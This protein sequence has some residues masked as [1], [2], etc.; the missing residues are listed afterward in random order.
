MYRS[1]C[2][3]PACRCLALLAAF[4][5]LLP[6][7]YA[8]TDA[9]SEV[10]TRV[11]ERLREGR[12]EAALDA[13]DHE[14]VLAALTAEERHVLATEYWTF[15]VSAPAVISVVRHIEQKTVPFWLTED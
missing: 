8:D 15:S 3:S 9:V 13:L 5:L 14:T 7:S 1:V 10:M 12:D 11:T 4:L 6:C 2:F